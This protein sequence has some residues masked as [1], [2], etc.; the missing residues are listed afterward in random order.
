MTLDPILNAPLAVQIHVF[1][2]VP[3]FVLGAFMFWSRK[4]TRVHKLLG[5][6]WVALMAVTALA[7]FFI[8]EIRMVGDFSPIHLLSLLALF[9]CGYIIWTARMRRFSAH[10]KA[11]LALYWGGIGLAGAFTI[12]PGRIMNQALLGGSQN[13]WPIILALAGL[14]VGVLVIFR[15]DKPLIGRRAAGAALALVA[16]PPLLLGSGGHA[17]AAP[18]ATDIVTRTP[19]WVWPLL[20]A[21]LWLGWTRS[22][23]RTVPKARVLIL[24]IVLA[25]IGIGSF[26]SNGGSAVAASVLLAGLAAGAA[27][28]QKLARTEG[29]LLDDAGMVH[30]KGEWVSMGLI[31][32]IF[33]S[34][35]AAGVAQ[36]IDPSL[37]HSP[38]IAL[39]LALVSGFSIGLTGMRALV[40]TGLRT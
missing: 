13:V 37:H 22:R 33:A 39:P 23:P 14:C 35:F 27:T 17:L 8:H 36:G 12:V 24:P 40:Q 2:V 3:A 9:S 16:A 31:L 29:K 26:F 11:V 5:R 21:L 25:G 18:G 19:V 10:R 30:L 1:T 20:V 34:R 7:S 15:R 4:G 38:A 28:G 6:V 32:A